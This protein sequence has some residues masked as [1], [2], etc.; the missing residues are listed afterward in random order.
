M[1]S[2]EEQG[3][4]L[5][6]I[7]P[8]GLLSFEITE[9]DAATSVAISISIIAAVTGA[10]FIMAGAVF[11]TYRRYGPHGTHYDLLD[12]G[13]AIPESEPSPEADPDDSFQYAS[14]LDHVELTK[15]EGSSSRVQLTPTK[16]SMRLD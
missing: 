13:Y 5:D 7:P 4:C 1:L 6:L 3:C 14:V 2:A 15:S 16:N 12:A 9:A 11:A 8:Q 10:V